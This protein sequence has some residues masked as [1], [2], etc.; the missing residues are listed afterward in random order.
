MSAMVFQIT[1][2]SIV[3]STLCSGPDQRENQCSASLAYVTGIPR[4]LVNSP[5]K[6]PVMLKMFHLMTSC[7]MKIRQ[8]LT[9]STAKLSLIHELWG[10][11][12]NYVNS[13]TQDCSN[14]SALAME[15]LQSCTKPPIWP[16]HDDH[17]YVCT[18]KCSHTRFITELGSHY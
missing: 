10:V 5:H 3:Y 17:N 9:K 12:G 16:H 13:F 14:S 2:I 1:S 6:G 18:A 15:L 11:M 8:P 7:R 4:W